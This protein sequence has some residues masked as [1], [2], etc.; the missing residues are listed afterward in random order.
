MRR[1]L[2]I[3]NS[4]RVSSAHHRSQ[5]AVAELGAKR[6]MESAPILRCPSGTEGEAV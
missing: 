4:A 6:V 3:G 5:Q 1:Y 2:R